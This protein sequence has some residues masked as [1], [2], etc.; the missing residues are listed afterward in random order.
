MVCLEI[1][2]A[3]WLVYDVLLLCFVLFMRLVR[4]RYFN[5]YSYYM[6][7]TEEHTQLVVRCMKQNKDAVW[8]LVHTTFSCWGA[9]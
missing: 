3:S 9:C 7:R 1:R 4:T 5:A 2:A 6:I 8:S